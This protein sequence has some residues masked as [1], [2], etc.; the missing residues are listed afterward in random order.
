MG[1]VG[2]GDAWQKAAQA[3]E[4]KLNSQQKR[5]GISRPF[6]FHDG[7]EGRTDLARARNRLG[8][9]LQDGAYSSGSRAQ[10]LRIALARKRSD[11]GLGIDDYQAGQGAM[12]AG[13]I[14]THPSAPLINP[15]RRE[16]WPMLSR[17]QVR[18][19]GSQ[20]DQPC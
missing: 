4:D 18:Y 12:S 13:Y 14:S 20:N 17:L 9:L 11:Y 16:T 19:A 6:S 8:S 7:K 15:T 3:L 2:A 10:T 5:A 1:D